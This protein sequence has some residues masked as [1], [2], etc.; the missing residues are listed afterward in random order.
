M[1]SF[2]FENDTQSSNHAVES[3]SNQLDRAPDFL[4]TGYVVT[5][6]RVVA[7][8]GSPPTTSTPIPPTPTANGTV[9]PTTASGTAPVTTALLTSAIPV[10]SPGNS[11]NE[12]ERG[13]TES[14]TASTLFVV[15]V[16]VGVVA[17]SA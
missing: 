3:L 11:S 9:V 17:S 13:E 4:P 2:A 7:S 15:A 10:P 14:L 16:V 8:G 12:G 6:A 5:S 1:G